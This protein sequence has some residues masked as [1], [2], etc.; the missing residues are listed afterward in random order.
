MKQIKKYIGLI[1][2]DAIVYKKMI[3]FVLYGPVM[4]F[5]LPAN[6][7]SS[8][9]LKSFLSPITM[10]T[11]LL[12]VLYMIEEDKNKGTELLTTTSYTRND[13]VVSRYLLCFF[14][15]ILQ[16]ILIFIAMFSVVGNLE[17]LNNI[18]SISIIFGVICINTSVQ[19]PLSFKFRPITFATIAMIFEFIIMSAA[20]WFENFIKYYFNNLMSQS[21]GVLIIIISIIAVIVSKIISNKI[22]L[23][24]DL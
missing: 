21:I 9:L 10:I 8:D 15:S 1:K 19:V 16:M 4:M 2:K 24:K 13:I 17:S 20:I 7:L 22:Y 11:T 3:F 5:F 6:F 14:I 18:I 12:F 23:K